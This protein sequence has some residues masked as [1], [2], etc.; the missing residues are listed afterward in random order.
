MKKFILY[1]FLGLIIGLCSCRV[2][3]AEKVILPVAE[4]YSPGY[5][6]TGDTV[7]VIGIGL[8]GASVKVGG[9]PVTLISQNS[10]EV[11]FIVTSELKQNVQGETNNTN[12][13][14]ISFS[15]GSNHTFTMP[16][17]V[18]YVIANGDLSGNGWLNG[19]TQS[20]G[21]TLSGPAQLIVADFDNGGIRNADATDKFDR[22]QFEGLVKVGGTGLITSYSDE[23]GATPAGGNVLSVNL[24]SK[25]VSP[26]TSGFAGEYITRSE[27]TN[28]GATWPL[29]FAEYLNSPIKDNV[30]MDDTYINLCLF[31]NG[32]DQSILDVILY[33]DNLLLA[34]RYRN[35]YLRTSAGLAVGTNEWAW[36]NLKFSD[37][38][39]NFGGAV[40]INEVI[41]ESI[42]KIKLDFNHGAVSAIDAGNPPEDKKV[43]IYLDQ[44]VI[45]QGAPYFGNIR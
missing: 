6:K 7:R 20:I 1:P 27:L 24:E 2:D 38:A 16:L 14:G 44:I 23:R 42:N 34:D 29:N 33:N 31:R 9:Q 21:D 35:R 13:I 39:S 36:V 12:N 15:D 45:T 11:A 40:D 43:E 10:K 17:V 26:N 22:T 3:K 25:F 4:S 37:F 19:S 18:N 8:D 5:V 28:D 32:Q 30:S 41:F